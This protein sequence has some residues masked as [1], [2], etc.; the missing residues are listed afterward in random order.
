M[1]QHYHVRNWSEYNAGLVKRG[2][3]TFWIS[4]EVLKEW[5]N[6]DW[7]GEP[8]SPV[9][10]SDLAIE[11]MVVLKNV[12]HLGGRQASGFVGSIFALMGVA[13]PVPDHTTL[14]RRMGK[15]NISLP[16]GEQTQARHVVVDSTGIKVYGEGEWKVRQHGVGKRRTWRKLH[17]GVDETTGEIV[18]VVVSTNNVGDAEVLPDLLEQVDGDIEQVSGD[19]A[20]DSEGSYQDITARGARPVIPPYHRARML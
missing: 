7:S 6:S 2:S 1:K 18:A 17:L 3:L 12:F 15:L 9:L 5:F 13:L 20:Y 19:G 11:T 14:S 4:D 16:I 10:Y 8:G